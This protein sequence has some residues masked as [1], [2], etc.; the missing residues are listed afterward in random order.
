MVKYNKEI[1]CVAF[2][3]TEQLI[4]IPAKDYM[5]YYFPKL[6]K[7][8]INKGNFLFKLIKSPSIQEEYIISRI[9]KKEE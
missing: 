7:Q 1:S 3:V 2:G 5:A 8:I 6:K 4:D 9:V